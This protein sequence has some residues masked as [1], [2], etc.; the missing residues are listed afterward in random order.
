MLQ[1]KEHLSHF[2]L[3]ENLME[4]IS[5]ITIRNLIKWSLRRD[6][7]T[8]EE[9][10]YEGFSLMGEGVRHVEEKTFL[11]SAFQNICKMRKFSDEEYYSGL[12]DKINSSK[13]L[14]QY[15]GI[16]W[17]PQFRKLFTLV[18]KAFSNREPI[19]LVGETGCGKTTMCQ[20]IAQI[21]NIDFLYINCHK[22][23]EV[24][25]FLGSW[26]PVRDKDKIRRKLAELL[27]KHHIPVEQDE[28]VEVIKE[29]VNEHRER[30]GKDMEEMDMLL[31]RVQREFV[32]V[33][34]KLIQAIRN[35]GVFLIDEISL[36]KDNVLERFNSLLEFEREIYLHE[37][38][39]G[40]DVVLKAHQNFFLIAT[41][42]PSGDFGKRELSP[43]LRNRFTEIWVTSPLDYENIEKEEVFSYIGNIIERKYRQDEFLT[44]FLYEFVMF[45]NK[46]CH[47]LFAPL[48]L[49]DLETFIQS[50]ANNPTIGTNL[51]LRYC[52]EFQF[53]QILGQLENDSII[54][55]LKSKLHQF[56]VQF[57]D[58]FQEQLNYK[59]DFD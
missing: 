31:E 36:A 27:G 7:L 15:Q 41:M 54:Q 28:L 20:L 33:D 1:I 35:G 59:I 32:W 51:R 12:F 55:L 13:N 16:E 2:N 21:L 3:Q 56:T 23:T 25:D 10:A 58:I 5:L 18:W 48:N 11:K 14:M 17:S 4:Q 19:L 39:E 47:N 38:E 49:R 8:K 57:P 43:A 9:F 30:V 22:N 34:G 42:N 29:R 46:N 45:V 44:K 40:N 50:Y 24:S 52:F 37:S 6:M 53:Q 26:R